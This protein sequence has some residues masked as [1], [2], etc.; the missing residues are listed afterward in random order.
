MDVNRRKVYEADKEVVGK[1]TLLENSL[2]N[3]APPTHHPNNLPHPTPSSE[4]LKHTGSSTRHIAGPGAALGLVTVSS[5]SA[6]C[7]PVTVSSPGP[8]L[9]LVTVSGPGAAFVS[10]T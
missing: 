3:H 10:A 2:G 5:P 4:L 1:W 6:A 9:G 8:V 7:V